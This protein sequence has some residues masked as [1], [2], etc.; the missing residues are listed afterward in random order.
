[1]LFP[2]AGRADQDP[3]VAAGA[4]KMR[5]AVHRAI[6]RGEPRPL[7]MV[8]K[9]SD[10]QS[11]AVLPVS[12][13]V[14]GT[15]EQRAASARSFAR[16]TDFEIHSTE[17]LS[18]TGGRAAVPLKTV[19]SR[20]LVTTAPVDERARFVKLRQ[21]LWPDRIVDEKEWDKENAARNTETRAGGR[22]G[23]SS[24]GPISDL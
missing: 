11:V 3:K 9:R 24:A 17:P 8:V 1:M 22:R 5:R 7:G 4:A 10:G 19:K 23:T 18:P 20:G 15:A 21:S 16:H 14:G 12:T 13:H 2:A 6:E